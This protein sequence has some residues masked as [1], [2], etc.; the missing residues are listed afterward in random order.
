MEDNHSNGS[1]EANAT[2]NMMDV[3]GYAVVW[4]GFLLLI[5]VVLGVLPNFSILVATR[6]KRQT[7]TWRY[8]LVY[9]ICICNI[10]FCIIWIPLHFGIVVSNYYSEG[11][12][13]I[14]CY[15]HLALFHF[16]VAVL[17][18][19]TMFLGVQRLGAIWSQYH[20]KHTN[21][22]LVGLSVVFTCFV[23][24][25]CAVY[26]CLSYSTTYSFTTCTD[27]LQENFTSNNTLDNHWAE[28]ILC[29]IY[30]AAL[31][32]TS[33][34]F[35]ILGFLRYLSLRKRSIPGRKR[36][37][38][39]QGMPSV[40]GGVEDDRIIVST[41]SQTSPTKSS[42]RENADIK[43]SSGTLST[44]KKV[45]LQEPTADDI[46]AINDN[47]NDEDDDD[48]DDDQFDLKMRMKLSTSKRSSGRRHT[49]A[50]I[51]S[52]ETR[53]KGRRG[54][55]EDHHSGSSPLNYQYIRKWSVDIVALQDQL[56]NPKLHSIP[57]QELVDFRDKK[58]KEIAKK[59]DLKDKE[60]EEKITKQ[61]KI[62]EIALNSKNAELKM[63]KEQISEEGETTNNI[64]TEENTTHNANNLA[65]GTMDSEKNNKSGEI[66]NISSADDPSSSSIEVP[67]VTIETGNHKSVVE[68]VII[69]TF[70]P[71]FD[72]APTDDKDYSIKVTERL[73]SV[74]KSVLHMLVVLVCLLPVCV[75]LV[76]QDNCVSKRGVLMTLLLIQ[77]PLHPILIAWADPVIQQALRRLQQKITSL[78]CIC[79]CNI[80]KGKRC[81]GRSTEY[82][83]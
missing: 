47:Y 69:Q 22:V 39:Y 82:C 71:P 80:G 53:H 1:A 36:S 12:N 9:G 54:S 15:A 40:E 13:S 3:E 42:I 20:G 8:G 57:I 28:T 46:H 83:S 43:K 16:A 21:N 60:K 37:C 55:M 14:V 52:G 38:Q 70:E 79:Y 81:L 63:I 23:G 49:V 51:G 19:S 27:T 41:I 10:I 72:G 2:S 74:W 61:E 68:D 32:S 34:I 33:I 25:L 56:E 64:E 65:L 31:V 44:T 29:L 77:C 30:V 45:C 5:L 35:I 18:C 66:V 6:C 50:N 58:E 76:L 24:C 17:S 59:E 75:F 26:A 62:E 73:R 11:V 78:R 4:S 48:D 67:A 7:Q